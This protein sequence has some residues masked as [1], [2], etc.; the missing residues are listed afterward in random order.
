[1]KYHSRSPK[2]LKRFILNSFL[3]FSVVSGLYSQTLDALKDERLKLKNEIEN[4]SKLLS[5][6]KIEQNEAIQYLGILSLQIKNRQSIIN[7]LN[8][9]ISIYRTKLKSAEDSIVKLENDILRNKLAYASLVE[10][11]YKRRNSFDALSYVLGSNS[12]NQAFMRY[13]MIQEINGYRKKQVMVL[14]KN[15]ELLGAEKQALTRIKNELELKLIELKTENNSLSKQ[16]NDK[17][18]YVVSLKG[19]EKQLN[20]EIRKKKKLDEALEEKLLELIA[21]ASRTKSVVTEGNDIGKYRGKLNKPVNQAVIISSFG[22]HDH[23]FLRGVKVKNNGVDF[24][25]AGSGAVRSVFKGEISRV[26]SIPGYNKA[27]IVRHGGYFTVYANLT[28]VYVKQ[29]QRVSTDA[30]IGKIFSGESENSNTLHFEIWKES[31]KLDPQI[32]LKM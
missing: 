6:N 31:E 21:S 23:P 29:G 14:Q 8:Q 19:R 1:M 26:I 13:R 4:T 27:V 20:D 9:E 12:F 24:K 18:L 22:E 15:E 11:L 7:G 10:E 5:N 28:E 30:E 3:I 25:V 32:W 17:E 16:Q 2:N